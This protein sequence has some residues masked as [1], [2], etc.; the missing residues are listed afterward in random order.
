MAHRRFRFICNAGCCCV[1]ITS[2][3]VIIDGVGDWSVMT[4]VNDV[5][6]LTLL[7]DSFISKGEGRTSE[8]FF[9]IGVL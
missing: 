8:Q 1:I 2:H 7:P 9:S 5:I 3:G 6:S 4:D